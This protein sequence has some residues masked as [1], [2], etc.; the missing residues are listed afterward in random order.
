[1]TVEERAAMIA[2]VTEQTHLPFDFAEKRTG[3]PAELLRKLVRDGVIDGEA[4]YRVM[5]IVG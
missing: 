4:P 1:M 3:I 5:G 2:Y